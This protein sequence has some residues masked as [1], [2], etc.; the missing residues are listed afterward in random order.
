MQ[1]TLKKGSIY[2]CKNDEE[3]RD[4]FIVLSDPFQNGFDL[5]CIIIWI[6]GNVADHIIE[7][8]DSILDDVHEYEL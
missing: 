6:S 3:E 7:A 1:T 2:V 8:T 4:Y 5:Q